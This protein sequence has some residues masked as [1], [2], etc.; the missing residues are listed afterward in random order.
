MK[1]IIYKITNMVNQKIYIGYTSKTFEQRFRRHC[2]DSTR[3]KKGY[4]QRALCKYG[5]HNFSHEIIYESMDGKHIKDAEIYF[6]NYFNSDKKHIGYNQHRGG[7]GGSTTLGRKHSD[8]TKQKI[9]EA[10]LGSKRS[11]EI[12]QKL[13]GRRLTQEKK[14]AIGNFHRGKKLTDSHILLLK[15]RVVSEETRR[16]LR[17]RKPSKET[18]EK[19]SNSLKGRIVSEETRQKLSKVGKGRKLSENT[20][21]KLREKVVSEETRQNMSKARKGKYMGENNHFFGKKHSEET[22]SKIAA[23]EYKKGAENYERL[24]HIGKQFTKENHPLSKSITINGQSYVSIS[25]A[26]RVLDIGK[27]IIMNRVKKYGPH[28]LYINGEWSNDAQS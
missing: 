4:F 21:Q 17:N 27:H 6:I 12:K 24:I 23:R 7:G 9:R 10:H 18:R 15:N 13:R 28:L 26:S 20:K 3:A 5:V 25:E 2:M 1:F 19:M 14:D 16:K 11:E 8:A 22:R